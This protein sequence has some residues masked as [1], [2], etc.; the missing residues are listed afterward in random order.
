MKNQQQVTTNR[1]RPIDG[2]AYCEAASGNF[3][4]LVEFSQY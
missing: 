1:S 3:N 4:Q 2:V